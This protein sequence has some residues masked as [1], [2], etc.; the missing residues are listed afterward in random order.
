MSTVQDVP[1]TPQLNRRFR[2]QWEAVQ[3]SYVLLYPEGMIRLNRSAAEILKFCDGVTSVPDIIA[4]LELKFSK[5]ALSSEV[6]H[7]LA[8]AFTQDWISQP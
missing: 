5:P 8:H 4:A 7:F 3:D 6:E 2:L 1:A